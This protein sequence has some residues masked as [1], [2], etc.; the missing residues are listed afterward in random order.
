MAG[1]E[2]K[3]IHAEPHELESSSRGKGYSDDLALARLGKKQVLRV[4]Q[5]AADAMKQLN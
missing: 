3:S 1:H 2:I 5:Q 4:C